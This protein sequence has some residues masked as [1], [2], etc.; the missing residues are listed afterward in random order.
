MLAKEAGDSRI[1]AGI[2]FEMDNQEGVTMGRQI[3]QKYIDW[4]ANDGSAK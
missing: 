4:A 1:W 3:A 2:H